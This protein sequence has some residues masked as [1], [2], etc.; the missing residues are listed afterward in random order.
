MI[1]FS[2]GKEFAPEI[3]AEIQREI[4][5]EI[6]WWNGGD[7]PAGYLGVG[8]KIQGYDCWISHNMASNW[9]NP[10]IIGNAGYGKGWKIICK[11]ENFV[12]VEEAKTWIIDVIRHFKI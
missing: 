6:H 2:F 7:V 5:T 3:S 11:G 1:Y 4:P 9:F 8:A 10:K 12:T